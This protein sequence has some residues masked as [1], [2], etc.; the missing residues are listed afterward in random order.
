MIFVDYYIY[1]LLVSLDRQASFYI[2]PFEGLDSISLK[3]PDHGLF[4]IFESFYL[5]YII[6]FSDFLYSLTTCVSEAENQKAKFH[7]VLAR[8]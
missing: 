2:L 6:K 5:N 3:K 8:A 4:I 7:N 1:E